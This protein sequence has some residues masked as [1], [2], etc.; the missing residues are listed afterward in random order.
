MKSFD[1]ARVILEDIAGRHALVAADQSRLANCYAEIGT[2]QGKLEYG[3][4]GLDDA[5]KSQGESSSN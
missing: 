1:E 3:D 4:H 2:M 5:R